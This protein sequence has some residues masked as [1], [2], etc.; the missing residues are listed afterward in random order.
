V[1]FQVKKLYSLLCLI[2]GVLWGAKPVYDSLVLDRKIN[3]GLTVFDWTDFIKFA[4]PL[5]CIGGILALLS[6]YKKHVKVSAI[7][8]FI[9]LILNALFHFAE[10]YLTHSQIPFGLLFLLTGSIT[11]LVGSTLLVFQ[12]RK[13]A[14]IPYLLSYLALGLSVTTFLFCLLPFVS[15]ILND[16]IETPIMVGLMMFIGLFW[17]VIGGVLFHIVRATKIITNHNQELIQ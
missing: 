2:G 4:F 7:I 11:L 3:S 6:L 15:N 10:I 8:L 5:L 17:A 9:S 14:S 12:L 1:G 16:G 13:E